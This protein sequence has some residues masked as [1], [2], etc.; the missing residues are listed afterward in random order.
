MINTVERAVVLAK[1]RHLTISALSRVS[2]VPETTLRSARTR[3][4]QLSVD[5]IERLCSAMGISMSDFFDET[6]K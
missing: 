3:N 5:V 6:S 4:S 2:G 1:N